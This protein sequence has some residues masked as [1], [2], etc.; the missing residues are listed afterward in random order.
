MTSGTSLA[1]YKEHVGNYER[2]RG[3]HELGHSFVIQ[4]IAFEHLKHYTRPK[5]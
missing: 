5:E 2:F 4:K 3:I 1:E